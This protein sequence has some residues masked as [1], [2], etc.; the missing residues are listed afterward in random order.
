MI[1]LNGIGCTAFRISTGMSRHPLALVPTNSTA[2]VAVDYFKRSSSTDNQPARDRRHHELTGQVIL[3]EEKLRRI[4]SNYGVLCGQVK[5]VQSPEAKAKW[6]AQS[7]D[8]EQQMVVVRRSI[9]RAL[10]ALQKEF[11][12][13]DRYKGES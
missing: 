6:L 5:H 2:K 13:N 11:P 1:G 9:S 10:E 12:G 8:A 3:L 7:V 4:Q